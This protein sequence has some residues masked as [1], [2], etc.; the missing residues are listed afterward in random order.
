MRTEL[1]LFLIYIV[2][3]LSKLHILLFFYHN[4]GLL[5]TVDGLAIKTV[6]EK[7]EVKESLEALVSSEIVSKRNSTGEVIWFYN[8]SQR[9]EALVEELVNVYGT[10]QGK[11][12]VLNIL[13]KDET[14]TNSGIL[15]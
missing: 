15:P 12:G 8:P 6:L 2:N 10:P 9:K 14:G 3:S 13:I 5:D 11:E 1:K 7:R 4:R